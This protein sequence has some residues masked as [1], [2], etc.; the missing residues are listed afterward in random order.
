MLFKSN[1]DNGTQAASKKIAIRNGLRAQEG[2][3]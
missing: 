3:D 1:G 2:M